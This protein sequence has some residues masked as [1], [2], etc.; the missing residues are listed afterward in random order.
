MSWMALKQA[1]IGPLPTAWPVSC[2][3]LIFNVTM[4]LFGS[5]FPENVPCRHTRLKGAGVHSASCFF[6]RAMD[7]PPLMAGLY[8]SLLNNSTNKKNK[9]SRVEGLFVSGFLSR[10]KQNLHPSG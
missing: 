5:P 3:P 7:Y 2:L 10:H 1:S 4:A 8:N 6:R 9:P